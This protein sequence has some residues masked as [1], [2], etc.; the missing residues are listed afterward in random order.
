[1]LKQ[2]NILSLILMLGVVCAC[3][4]KE[5]SVV[6]A[7]PVIKVENASQQRT[8]VSTVMHFT[9][10]LDKSATA[11]V[12]FD[13]TT[14]DQTA[15]AEKNYT[16]KS[17]KIIIDAG[18]S[19]SEIT[20]DISGDP[21]D[22][23]ENNLT[24]VLQLS[25][26]EN[27]TIGT[28]S[29]TGTIITENGMNF[30]TDNT[31]YST[32][33]TYAGCSPV[34]SDEFSGNEL[35]QNSWNYEIGNDGDGWGNN[36][37]QY[38]TNSTNNVFVSN[39]NLIIEARKEPIGGFNYSSARITTQNK[40]VFTFGRVDIRAKLPKE[41]GIWPAL[42]MLGANIVFV[43]WPYCG[44]I[45]IMELLGQDPSKVYA[46]LHY[47]IS[48]TSEGSKGNSYFLPSGAFSD[49][50]HVFSMI[51]KEDRIE[52]L[53]DDNTILSVDKTEIT[54]Y[55]YPFNLPFFFIFNVAVGGN[56]PGSPN[57]TTIF[58]Q[59]MIVDY[60]RVFQ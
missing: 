56:W 46:T 34:W 9:V 33:T 35:D 58:P 7:I 2:L 30:T 55:S 26:P 8:S 52:I 43:G 5:N 42:W 13:F 12:S 10:T 54:D 45:D 59:R 44:E 6:P 49:E 22:K 53:V 51:W 25:N 27:A 37:L 40:K 11:P 50:F 38:Y 36:E 14:A 19:N 3:G 28:A 24:F 18:K 31:G 48:S 21:T 57:E 60:I 47:G 32:P 16:A 39:G 29:A 23:R 4:K 15:V 17:G 20:I 41:Q 1:M